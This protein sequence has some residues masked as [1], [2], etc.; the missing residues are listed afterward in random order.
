MDRNR[1]ILVAILSLLVL[2]SILAIVDISLK[3]PADRGSAKG[4]QIPSMG[5]GVAIVR[6]E[7]AIELGIKSG[8]FSNPAG[9]ESVIQH[10]DEIEKSQYIKAVVLRINSPG[11]TVTASQEIYQKLWRLR[12]KNIILV[13][14][15]AEVA[16]SG[17]YYVAS[18]CN[19]I[20]ANQGTITGSI[21]VIAASP[22]LKRLFENF[23]IRMNVV[24]S[25]R[26]KDI[27][28]TH[29]DMTREE[30]QILQ[31][32]IDSSYS[33]F[34]KDI[35]LGRNMNQSEILPY[36]DGRIFDGEQA[37]R[38]KFIDMIGTF[39]ESVEKAKE[40]AKL[41]Q[42]APVYEENKSTIQQLLLGLDSVFSGRIFGGLIQRE[43]QQR[44]EYRYMQ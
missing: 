22:N 10:L 8:P 39:E 28:S 18:A 24:K 3:I 29:R 23:G 16:A 15:M 9:A 7:G 17:G 31:G 20:V 33:R 13:A 2:S 42:D 6:I 38:I 32:L 43:N 35:A 44:L 34:I 4:L 25:G 26:H 30:E 5:Q 36:A 1:K 27:F 19:Y 11:G 21:G 12:K 37:L 40:L 41:P 14:S